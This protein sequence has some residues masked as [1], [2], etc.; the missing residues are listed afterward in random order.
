MGT[1]S[2]AF[3]HA[4]RNGGNNTSLT[5]AQLALLGD[6]FADRQAESGKGISDEWKSYLRD[7]GGYGNFPSYVV[8]L[9]RAACHSTTVTF[10]GNFNWEAYCET[11]EWRTTSIM[12][13]DAEAHRYNAV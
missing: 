9:D 12:E 7:I 1:T 8:C 3:D 2:D 5:E 4:V 13:R 10:L 11:C 6:D